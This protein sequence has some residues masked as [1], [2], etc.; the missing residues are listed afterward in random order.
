MGKGIIYMDMGLWCFC[1][2][3]VDA[4]VWSLVDMPEVIEC[5]FEVFRNGFV[6][7]L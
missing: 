2:L 5:Q 6:F 4:K 7:I 1:G 3:E